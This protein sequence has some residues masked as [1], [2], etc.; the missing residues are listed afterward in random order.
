MQCA[1]LAC[2]MNEYFLHSARLGF[3]CWRDP[4]LQA[5]HQPLGRSRRSRGTSA[6]AATRY[7]EVQARLQREIEAE[8]AHGMQY[9]PIFLLTTGEHIGCCG[10]RPREGQPQIPELGVH[11]A[12]RHWRQGYA[13]EA[14]SRVIAYAFSCGNIEAIFAG[15]NPEN[16]ASRRLLTR[17]GFVY[18]HDEFYAPTGLQHPS[19]ILHRPQAGRA[20]PA[21]T[22]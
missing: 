14:A 9:W 4:D 11:V 17:L 19:Y 18:T 21:M 3:R 20:G 22:L 6:R 1:T 5:G 16:A 7:P 10:L 15:H 2:R 8:R 13:F 12:S